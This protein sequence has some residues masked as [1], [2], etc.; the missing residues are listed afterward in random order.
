ME[1]ASSTAIEDGLDKEHFLAT[2]NCESG[3]EYD[4][5]G[6]D[7][8]SIG[9]AQIDFKYHPE[10]F[11]T[12]ALDPRWSILWMAQMW[13]DGYA[14]WWSCYNLKAWEYKRFQV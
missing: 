12:Q 8:V 13:K 3:F 5:K 14:H 4:A 10:I 7:G 2:L 1:F 9:A 6:D 11:Y